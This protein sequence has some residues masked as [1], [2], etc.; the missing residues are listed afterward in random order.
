MYEFIQVDRDTSVAV[1][2]L[3]RP[4]RLNAWHTPMRHE[5]IAAL[6]ALNA[7]DT[8]KA[9][10]ITGAGERAFCAGQDLAETQSYDES[11]ADGWMNEWD[12]LYGALRRM[13]KPTVAAL[14]GLAV[15]SAFQFA[16]LCDIRVAHPKVRMGQ[17]EI[18]AGIPSITGAWVIQNAVSYARTVEMI[19]TGRL[20]EGEECLQIG[21]VHHLVAQDAVLSKASDI[22]AELAA[23]PPVTMRLNKQRLREISEIGFRDAMNSGHPYHREAFASGEPQAQMAKFFEER[24]APR[25][26]R[27]RDET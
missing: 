26:A 2:T 15:G 20:I 1:I 23:K 8:N 16:L 21:L 19:L 14:N 22:A 4:E 10:I 24:A 25:A 3:N 27:A 17:P 6:D 5:I 18:N 13:D 11:K 7:D 12:N 9:V